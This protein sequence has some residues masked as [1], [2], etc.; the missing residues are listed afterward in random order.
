MSDENKKASSPAGDAEEQSDRQKKERDRSSDFLAIGMT[1]G[2]C[3]GAVVGF[4]SGKVALCISIFLIVGVALGL[5]LD[6]R[7]AKKAAPPAEALPSD[8]QPSSEPG[9]DDSP[10]EK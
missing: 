8:D 5:F 3:I 2:L 10:A 4:F 9:N 6:D 1:A 7:R